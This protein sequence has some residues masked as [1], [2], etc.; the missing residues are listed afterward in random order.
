MLP[1]RIRRIAAS[2]G[3]CP[4]SRR[5]LAPVVEVVDLYSDHRDFVVIRDLDDAVVAGT[6]RRPEP[7]SVR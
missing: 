2:P 1:Q 6:V 4:L 3:C 5:A 7:T